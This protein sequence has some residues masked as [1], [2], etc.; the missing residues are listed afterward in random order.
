M[1]RT[2]SLV[3]L[4]L[5]HH[6]VRLF[7]NIDYLKISFEIKW[8]A[9]CWTDDANFNPKWNS[10]DGK[11]D[12]TSFHGVYE[13]RNKYPLNVAGRTG[14]CGRGLL[15]RYAVNHAADPVVTRWKRD[16][17]GKIIKHSKSNKYVI[18]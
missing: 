11:I 4:L 7:D 14:I 17:N 13:V 15:G 1:I 18:M 5:I 3:N 16:S 8:I 12:R 6:L 10:V 9:F 2:I